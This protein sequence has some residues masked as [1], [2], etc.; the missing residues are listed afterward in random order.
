MVDDWHWIGGGCW[1]KKDCY[2]M[3]R[4]GAEGGLDVHNVSDVS[5]AILVKNNVLLKTS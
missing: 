1:G 4:V 3:V 2:G 5:N